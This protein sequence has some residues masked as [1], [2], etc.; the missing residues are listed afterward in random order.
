MKMLNGRFASKFLSGVYVA[1]NREIQWQE[2]RY[3]FHKKMSHQESSNPDDLSVMHMGS[4]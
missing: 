4:S 1:N 3:P 2:R